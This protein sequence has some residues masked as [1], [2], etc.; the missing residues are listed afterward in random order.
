M[1]HGGIIGR[2]TLVTRNFGDGEFLSS[3]TIRG[4][5]DITWT[6]SRGGNLVNIYAESSARWGH[7]LCISVYSVKGC[8]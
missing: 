6:D 2:Q 1:R 8:C 4:T 3:W 7:D 5:I